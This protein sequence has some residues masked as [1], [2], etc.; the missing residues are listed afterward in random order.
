MFTSTRSQPFRPQGKRVSVWLPPKQLKVAV[1]IDNLSNF[2]QMALDIAPDIMA[3]AMLR[4]H[5]PKKY[6][7]I[8]KMEEVKDEYNKKYP[9]DPR[10]AKRL[11]KWQ[12]PSPKLPETLL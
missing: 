3:W 11:G 12:E 8:H 7:Q 5:D 10:T 9:L 6:H 1:Q 4:E 2:F